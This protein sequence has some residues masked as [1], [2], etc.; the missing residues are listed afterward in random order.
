MFNG[1]S[2]DFAVQENPLII[3]RSKSKQVTQSPEKI[4]EIMK[5]KGFLASFILGHSKQCL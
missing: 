2:H 1:T 4:A 5:K 3:F